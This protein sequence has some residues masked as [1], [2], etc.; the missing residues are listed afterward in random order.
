ML[1]KVWVGGGR[2]LLFERATTGRLIL[3][4][5][6]INGGKLKG[7]HQVRKGGDFRQ[8]YSAM[9]GFNNDTD[10]N[11]K[12]TRTTCTEVKVLSQLSLVFSGT[13]SKRMRRGNK[14][15]RRGR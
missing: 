8:P 9:G 7:L 15:E 1:L 3:E 6:N 5:F 11:C 14:K 4:Q 13:E 12:K 2:D 10:Q